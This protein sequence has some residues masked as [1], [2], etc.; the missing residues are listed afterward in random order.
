MNIYK[1]SR[2]T[3]SSIS[4]GVCRLLDAVFPLGDERAASSH[5]L[6]WDLWVVTHVIEYREE[7]STCY[8][9]WGL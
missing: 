3:C 9:F 4:S 6:I 5:C 8:T 7:D 1:S 2:S